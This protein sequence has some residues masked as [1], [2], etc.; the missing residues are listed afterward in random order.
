MCVSCPLSVRNEEAAL[1][2]LLDKVHDALAK[3]PTKYEE[4]CEVLKG[5]ILRPFSNRRHAVIQV[6]DCC[7]LLYV[8]VFGSSNLVHHYSTRSP[9]GRHPPALLQPPRHAVIQV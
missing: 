3:Y 8:E 2:L 5:D 9:Q 4:D 1:Q 6:R 7:R